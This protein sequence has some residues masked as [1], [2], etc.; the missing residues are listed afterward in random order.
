MMIKHQINLS[1]RSRLCREE[2]YSYVH[3]D[4][5]IMDDVY[6]SNLPSIDKAT[7]FPNSKTLKLF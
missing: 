6:L 5:S 3:H 7:Q 1:F 2:Y 4:M